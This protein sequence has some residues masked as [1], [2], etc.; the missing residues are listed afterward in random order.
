M[1][2]LVGPNAILQLRAP[3]D[4]R[5]GE[6]L[7]ADMLRAAGLA[8][9]PDA[10]GM[11]EERVA[12]RA[13]AALPD[14]VPDP[15]A[16]AREAGAATAHYILAHRIPARAQWL[17]RHLPAPMAIPLLTRAIAAHA[18]TFSGSG[19][20]TISRRRPLT[21]EIAQNPLAGPLGCDWHVAVFETLYQSLADPRLR[22]TERACCAM[23]AE[24]CRFEVTR[25]A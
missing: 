13:H 14:L 4:A 1:T 8:D 17:L 2:A 24:A 25:P 5:G 15:R 19:A 20:F 10:T 16:V 12:A 11:I 22:V 7:I 21:L 9:W 6:A 23:G 18:W 3:L